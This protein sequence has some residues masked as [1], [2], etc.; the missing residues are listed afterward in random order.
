M[1]MAK[2]IARFRLQANLGD[3]I[4]DICGP[5]F[6]GFVTKWRSENGYHMS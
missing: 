3:T 6:F 1:S 2:L 4:I 5:I